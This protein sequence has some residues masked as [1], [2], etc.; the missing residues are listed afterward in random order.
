MIILVRDLTSMF[1][2]F[3]L[4]VVYGKAW[5]DLEYCL[6]SLQV[7]LETFRFCNSF[8]ALGFVHKPS[9]L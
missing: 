6:S 2:L 8:H 3:M 4:D 7:G 1:V 5:L 9:G